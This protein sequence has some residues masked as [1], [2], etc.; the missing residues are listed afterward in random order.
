MNAILGHDEMIR[1]AFRF[2]LGARC[3]WPFH[4]FTRLWT[5]MLTSQ[6]AAFSVLLRLYFDDEWR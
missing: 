2:P 5:V 1:H 4:R 6:G 3:V